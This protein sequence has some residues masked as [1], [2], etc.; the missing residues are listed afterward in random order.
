MKLFNFTIIALGI[1]IIMYLGGVGNTNSSLIVNSILLKNTTQIT[2]STVLP[3]TANVSSFISFDNWWIA[4]GI[5]LGGAFLFSGLKISIGSYIS[6]PSIDVV[7]VALAGGI[8][9][10]FVTDLVSLLTY[11]GSITNYS[12]WVFWVV[13]SILVPFVVMYSFSLFS[14]LK[15]SD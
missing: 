11:V 14:F 2:A 15:G 4:I 5:L 13:A 3:T 6:T 10:I 7:Y 8:Y 1:M 9:A 12:G